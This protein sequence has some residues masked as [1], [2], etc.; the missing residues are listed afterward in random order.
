[1]Q[2]P[3]REIKELIHAAAPGSSRWLI[4]RLGVRSQATALFLHFAF[5]PEKCSFSLDN[6]SGFIYIH[7]ST[8]YY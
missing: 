5:R 6:P 1:V 7:I 8:D 4:Q 2:Q 3:S